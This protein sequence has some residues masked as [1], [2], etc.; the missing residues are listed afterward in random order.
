[1]GHSRSK[2]GSIVQ[3]AYAT[4]DIEAASAV[5]AAKFGAGPFFVRKHVPVQDVTYRGESGEFDHS[6]SCG[7]WGAVMLEFVEDHTNGPSVINELYGP[8]E[9]GLHHVACF[10]DDLDASTAYYE[11]AGYPL[12]ATGNAYGLTRF[13]YVDTLADRGHFTELYEPSGRLLKF[14]EMVADAARGWDG[15]DPVRVL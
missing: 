7:Q 14:Y 4:Y 15:S 10:V 5:W 8:G 11:N 9:T 6:N 2:A 1:M 12:A 3:I 13:H